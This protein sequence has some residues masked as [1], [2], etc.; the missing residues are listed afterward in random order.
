[1][2]GIDE[3]LNEPVYGI[4][5]IDAFVRSYLIGLGE[6]GLDNFNAGN[7]T[8]LVWT[9]FILATLVTQLIFMNLL[10]A[11]M[12]D[13]FDRVQ[14]VMAQA[15]VKEK[16]TMINDYLWILDLQEEFREDKYI[17]IVELKTVAESGNAWE[18]KI[19]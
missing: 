7:D 6:F 2:Q 8:F 9:F 1:M 19:G 13:T 11:I 5:W 15:A 14:E 10:I 3:L 12:G 4:P 18:G 17:L 16:I